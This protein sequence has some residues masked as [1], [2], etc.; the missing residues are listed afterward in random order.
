MCAHWRPLLWWGLKWT[1]RHCGESR[2]GS[3]L[4]SSITV[5]QSFNCCFDFFCCCRTVWSFLSVPCLLAFLSLHYITWRQTVSVRWCRFCYSLLFLFSASLL[6]P[7]CLNPLCNSSLLVWRC[8]M[9]LMSV[10]INCWWQ[11]VLSSSVF[12]L[13]VLHLTLFEG[14]RDFLFVILTSTDAT[15]V[16]DSFLFVTLVDQILSFEFWNISGILFLNC[17]F[18]T[19]HS[20]TIIYTFSSSLLYLFIILI[21]LIRPSFDDLLPDFVT[22]LLKVKKRPLSLSFRPGSDEFLTAALFCSILPVN[23][24]VCL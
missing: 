14:Q 2:L 10:L 13:F 5:V 24:C 7:E 19:L 18:W 8:K 1:R 3:L 22:A 16:V 20:F 23:V 11:F 21:V 12:V 6:A 9:C 4:F 17:V 15:S